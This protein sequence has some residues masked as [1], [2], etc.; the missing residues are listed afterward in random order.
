MKSPRSRLGLSIGVLVGASVFAVGMNQMASAD[1]SN[2]TGSNSASTASTTGTQTTSTNVLGNP[3]LQQEKMTISDGYPTIGQSVTVS[4]SGLP[5]NQTFQLVW[6]TF[7][8]AWNLDGNTFIGESYTTGVV[9]MAST[10]SDANGNVTVTFKVPVGYGDIHQVGLVNTD[11]LVVSQGSVTVKPSVSMTTHSEPQGK[12]FDISMQ[13]IGYGAYSADYQVLYDNKLTGNVSAVTTNGSATF[14]VRAEG[15]GAHQIEIDPSSIGFPYLNEQQSPYSW[16]PSFDLPVTV[17]KGNPGDVIDAIPTPSPTTGTN[18]TASPGHG[19]TGS[20]FTL[21]GTSMPVD[22]ALTIEWSNTV[23][24]HVTSNGFHDAETVLGTVTTDANGGFTKRLTVPVNV[25]GPPHTIQVVD[26]QG[27][28]LGTT[29]YQI[30]PSLVSAPKTV[31]VGS[32]FT[33]HLQGGG[34]D[35]YDNVY[36][37]LY[38]NGSI[39]YACGFNSNGDMQIQ[40][41]ATGA[42]GKHFIDLYPTIQQ[43]N[44]KLPNV[45]LLPLLTYQLDHPGEQ[46]PAFH[47]VINV[48]N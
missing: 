31:K 46:Q 17:T 23:G 37:V 38:D 6:E 18:L 7:K 3:A 29:D 21:T 34:P 8:G 1:T 9:T 22:D 35:T 11:G 47:I 43:G 19:I 25:G 15:V 20:T 26:A 39:G 13:G 32:L 10:T 14:Q 33:V 45:Y 44:Q 12:F 5:A 36:S 28:S 16:K 41:R 24:N 42:P 40:I 27:K 4:A 2:T 30:Y 48:T